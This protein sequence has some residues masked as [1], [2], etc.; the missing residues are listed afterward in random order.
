MIFRTISS[1]QDQVLVWRNEKAK[2]GLVPTM[3]A[4]HKGHLS[5]VHEARRQCDRVIVSI[6]VNPTQFNNSSDLSAYP[7]SEHE[8]I[9]LLSGIDAVFLPSPQEMYPC[10]SV[11]RLHV[12]GISER[13]EGQHRPGHFDGMATVVMKLFNISQAHVG[14]FGEKDW[15][16]LQVVRQMV[17][18]FNH[19]ISIT[20]CETVRD[21]DGLA[22]S[23][24]NKR[25][26]QDER[27]KASILFQ[28]LS[29]T[30]ESIKNGKDVAISEKNGKEILQKSGFDKIDYFEVCDAQTLL[31]AADLTRPCR[32]LAA[33]WLGDVRLIDNVSV[34]KPQDK[35]L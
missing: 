23:S 16:Q 5:L 4:L 21:P 17:L 20:G 10:G 12:G 27:H 30:A 22:K 15:Q 11:S 34:P 25:L 26:S 32:V 19:T 7:R 9:Q 8:D 29:L 33:A 13:L 28:A 1:L 18:D 2:I 24:R 3:G 35:S 14:F 31:P 6:F